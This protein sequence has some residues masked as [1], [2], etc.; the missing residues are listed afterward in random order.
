MDD[1]LEP[2]RVYLVL[3]DNMSIPDGGVVIDKVS[4]ALGLSREEG[5][6]IAQHLEGIGWAKV[7]WSQI[8]LD[9][10]LWLTYDG[11]KMIAEWKR[12]RWQ[13]WADQHPWMMSM[14]SG[15]IAGILSG[16]G[17][18]WLVTRYGTSQ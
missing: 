15:V 12:P 7:Q 17:V 2:L 14:V 8:N 5:R 16:V 4:N 9:V 10:R 13:Q 11:L 1:Q 6:A 18:A 3:A